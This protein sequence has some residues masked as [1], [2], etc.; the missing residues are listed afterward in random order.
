V[1]GKFFSNFVEKKPSDE[2]LDE[3][4]QKSVYELSARYCHMEGYE[5]LDAP[6]PPPVE[7][8]PK[9]KRKSKKTKEET[10]IEDKGEEKKDGEEEKG[11][12]YTVKNLSKLN[13]LERKRKV[14]FI[15]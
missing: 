3:E 9:S 2:S 5:P 10:Q 11:L 1:T 12:L 4:L 15:Q 13:L 6:A 7:E 8:K 14:C